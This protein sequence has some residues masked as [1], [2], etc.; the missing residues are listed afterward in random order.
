M[1]PMRILSIVTLIAVWLWFGVAVAADYYVA[2]T[3]DDGNSGTESEPWATIQ[4]AADVMVAGD[5]VFLRGGVYHQTVEPINSGSPGNYITY[6]S[7]PGEEAIID[8]DDT[9]ASAYGISLWDFRELRYLKFSNLTLKNAGGANVYVGAD[10]AAKS[11]LVFDSLFID[12]GYLGIFFRKGVTN[13]SIT[14]CQVYNCQY[15]IYVDRLNENILIDNNDVAY[16]HLF[17]PGEFWTLNLQIQG[18][19]GSPNR[20]ITVS[21]NEVH[22]GDIQ[23]ISVWYCEDIIVR[24]NHCHNNG[25]TG[26]DCYGQ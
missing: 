24:N 14:N 16:S 26:I 19:P 17:R 1:C 22:H 20:N 12:N 23:G 21:N 15:N 5:Q 25:A 4:K 6:R 7:Y 10:G 11:H 18:A 8:V 13:S 2:P 3:G 9:S